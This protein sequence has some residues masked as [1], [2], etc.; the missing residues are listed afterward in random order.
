M[1]NKFTLLFILLSMY[2]VGCKSDED[3]GWNI[4]PPTEAITALHTDTF[5]IT[6]YTQQIDSIRSDHTSQSL[7][8]YYIDPV[9]G[10]TFAAFATQLNLPTTNVVFPSNISIDSLV[11]HLEYFY[12]YGNPKQNYRITYNVYTLGSSLSDSAIYSH[13]PIDLG[14]LIG[15][16][17]VIPNLRDSTILNGKKLPAQLRIQLSKNFAKKIVEAAYQG[18]LYNNS[19]FVNFL[20]GIGL[21]P[22]YHGGQGC[23]VSFDVTSKNS[24]MTLYYHI[25]TVARSYTFTIEKTTPRYTYFK[26]DYQQAHPALQAQLNGDSSLGQQILFLQ[27]MAGTKVIIKFPNIEKFYDGK[28]IIHQAKLLI[29]IDEN[30]Q[31]SAIY[32][33]P[34]ILVLLKVNSKGQFEYIL[35][36][37]INTNQANTPNY[38]EKTKTYSITLTRQLQ[39]LIKKKNATETFA[40]MI[41]GNA[42][43]PHRVVLAGS[44]HN[45]PMKL[46]VY[47]TPIK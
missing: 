39:E 32:P 35:D 12:I 38:D 5:T 29:P 18:H 14:E 4:Y 44:K 41:S 46:L 43:N 8:G 47:Y 19:S 22:V 37:A 26:H 6:A 33:I 24:G 16:K 2:V 15:S 34:K 11:L 25:D 13:R 31:T 21:V 3:T 27:S 17:S 1:H 42:V 10:T 40:L 28:V 23:M 36:Y 20:K 30:D 9:F 7:A 45:K